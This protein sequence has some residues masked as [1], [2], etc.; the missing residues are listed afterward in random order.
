MMIPE[1]FM[2]REDIAIIIPA[3]EYLPKLRIS[4][5]KFAS[6]M[7]EYMP[8]VPRT[9]STLADC[10]NLDSNNCSIFRG[11]ANLHVTFD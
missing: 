7:K 9:K 3:F 1:S 11:K 10:M 2:N 6:A 5:H 8:N 4:K